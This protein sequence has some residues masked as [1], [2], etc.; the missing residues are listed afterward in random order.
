MTSISF[1]TIA[2]VLFRRSYYHHDGP[3]G[4][5]SGIRLLSDLDSKTSSVIFSSRD[6]DVNIDIYEIK[7]MDQSQFLS[8]YGHLCSAYENPS[9]SIHIHYTELKNLTN[10]IYFDS[11]RDDLVIF[12]AM[13]AG[14]SSGYISR[15]VKISLDP[16]FLKSI[17]N[18]NNHIVYYLDR[19][20]GISVINTGFLVLGRTYSGRKV[21]HRFLSQLLENIHTFT[22]LPL[23]DL[24][25][26]IWKGI[27]LYQL[28]MEE[29]ARKPFEWNMY[30][31]SCNGLRL[32]Y[33][34]NIRN[35]DAKCTRM[36]NAP[37]C[38]VMDADFEMWFRDGVADHN[39][40][41]KLLPNNVA[42][43]KYIATVESV[44]TSNQDYGLTRWTRMFDMMADNDCLP[45]HSCHKC[46]TKSTSGPNF[47][48][49]CKACNVIC[50]CFCQT[51]CRI[52]PRRRS[53]TKQIMVRIP[54]LRNDAMRLIP[55]IIHQTYFEEPL[56]E[57]YPNFSRLVSSWK[58]SGWEYRFY[59]NEM[60]IRFLD[61]HFPPEIREAYEILLPGAYKADLFRYCV[62]LIYGGIYADI[63]V[64]LNMDLSKI[65]DDIGFVVPVDEPGRVDGTGSC[66]WN[67]LLA[68]AP[69]HPFI[70]KVIEMVVN[71]VRNR[72]TA[73]DIDDMLC[74]YPSLKHSHDWDLLF[75]TG[76][77]ILGAAV[78]SVLGNHMQTAIEP[79]ELDTRDRDPLIPGRSVI[80]AQNK[81]DI[82]ASHRFTW[83]K[84]NIIVATTDMPDYHDCKD[85][86]KHYS[87][88]TKERQGIFGLKNVYRDNMSA[89]EDIKFILKL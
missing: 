70:A 67:G 72:F 47:Q 10:D 62:L 68:A 37:C 29:Q 1:V 75:V 22:K 17:I 74:P 71:M 33:F 77:C 85:K 58:H 55:K 89:N 7:S 35:F 56:K 57:K 31:L 18:E 40:D 16:E 13:A 4:N 11:I 63:D 2:L 50:G 24:N 69:G 30:Q 27:K 9:N 26:H 84:K 15:Q 36:D 38:H 14:I 49:Q 6:S 21:A 59:D 48:S 61:V 66:L 28:I 43:S 42:N 44:N 73:V 23:T 39:T 64:L 41:S 87:A 52:R 34:Y 8:Q 3:S 79:G 25:Y 32:H 86:P 46:L 45:S 51:L 60:S 54:L 19:K 81:A 12:C 53:D 78:N 88:A 76:P 80:L 5:E 20:S 65:D 82:G 83:L